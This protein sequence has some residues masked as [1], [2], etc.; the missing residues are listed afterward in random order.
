MSTIVI[1]QGDP[2]ANEMLAFI[3][4]HHYSKRVSPVFS[5]GFALTNARGRIQAVSVVAEPPYPSIKRALC[6]RPED[7]A[8]T[9]WQSRMIAAGIGSADLDGLLAFSADWLR[10]AGYYYFYTMSEREAWVIDG[11]LQRLICPGF[12]GDTYHRNGWL[13]LGATAGR[14]CQLFMVDNRPVHIRQNNV[15]LTPGNVWS[16]YP[17]AH[18][19]RAV[20]SRV[21]DRWLQVLADNETE[22]AQRVLLIRYHVQLWT[23]L[24]Q[25]RL[26][27]RRAALTPGQ[28]R[29]VPA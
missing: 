28:T 27:I 26:F 18:E 24:I 6:R 14:G 22:R 2:N 11:A 25:P 12:S 1:R 23:P 20:Q 10:H 19:I 17:N 21:K 4:R 7:H 29:R 3:K 9:A 15:T 16:H 13:Y 5:V 8:R